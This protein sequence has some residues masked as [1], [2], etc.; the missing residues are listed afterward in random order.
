MDSSGSFETSLLCNI[1]NIFEITVDKWFELWYMLKYDESSDYFH[2]LRVYVLDTIK[3]KITYEKLL[4]DDNIN[5]WKLIDFKRW[6]PMTAARNT[7]APTLPKAYAS[8]IKTTVSDS[9]NK[10]GF[11]H[12]K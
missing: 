6:G 9:I 11:S 8:F 2:K 5:Y 7:N 10:G 4:Q 12:R 1:V 3:E